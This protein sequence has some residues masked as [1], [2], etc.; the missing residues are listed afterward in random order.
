MKQHSSK[1]HISDLGEQLARARLA[2]NIAQTEL[3]GKAGIS[4]RTLRRLES[5]EGGSMD[6][7]IRVLMALKIDS[8]LSVLFSDSAIRPMEHTSAGKS[9]R[10]RASGLNKTPEK[11]ATDSFSTNEKDK[12]T[13]KPDTPR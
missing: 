12:T 5:G 6:S 9:E 4:T 3:A 1:K 13:A 2:H 8:K 11:A 7:F 10:L